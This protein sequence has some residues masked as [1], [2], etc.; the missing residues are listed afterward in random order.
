MNII[1]YIGLRL[2]RA[3]GVKST[4]LA[5]TWIVYNKP[6]TTQ[7]AQPGNSSDRQNNSS[8]N[9]QEASQ[10]NYAHGGFL[11]ALGLRGHLSALSMIDSCEYLTQGPVTTAV[12]ILLGMSAEKR[13]SC[14]LSVS[15]ML[16]LH[17][18][19]LLPP[20][21]ATIDV[22]SQT[23]AAAVTGVGLLY[24]GSSHRLM[25]EFLLSEIGKAPT[26]E[27]NTND[28]ES[29]NLCCGIALGMVN[30]NRG[31]HLINCPSDRNNSGLSDLHLDER[32]HRL[33]TG[34]PD[35]KLNRRHRID[36]LERTVPGGETCSKIHEG[37]LINTDITAPGAT[38]ALGMIYF[39]SG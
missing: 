26:N 27:Q 23:Q 15:K 32:L 22:A 29:Y 34:G 2:P 33:I 39:Q 7:S 21:F 8:Q 11:M 4:E 16:C 35:D 14:D 25:T 36:G 12:G 1:L 6:F 9:T 3:S 13:G 24:Q 31:G 28:R 20:S 17:I 37:D 10:P 5:R 19:S 30:L 38:L 18:P